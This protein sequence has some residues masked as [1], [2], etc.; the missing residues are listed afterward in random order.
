MTDD[1]LQRAAMRAA[2][3]LGPW[4]MRV[5]REGGPVRAEKTRRRANAARAAARAKAKAERA[6]VE[7]REAQAREERRQA[8]RRATLERQKASGPPPSPRRC[9]L[10]GRTGHYAKDAPSCRAEGDRGRRWVAPRAGGKSGGG[11]ENV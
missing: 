7:R 10:C 11:G 5:L 9:S 8:K 1:E 6:A 3:S 4:R 2:T